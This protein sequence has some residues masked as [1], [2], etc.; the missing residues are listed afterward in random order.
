MESEDKLRPA[1][2]LMGR[3]SKGRS[4]KGVRMC[5]KDVLIR[6]M[7]EQTDDEKVGQGVAA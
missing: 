6:W 4:V 3:Q 1:T 2:L 5:V 7:K